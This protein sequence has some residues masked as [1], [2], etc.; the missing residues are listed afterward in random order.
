M[1]IQALAAYADT[2]LREQL[3]DPAFESKRVPLSLEISADGKFLGWIPHEETV[4]KGKKQF[5]QIPV[6]TVPK[7]PVN[8]NSGA[9]PLLA[10][11]D[12]KYVF[13]VGPWTKGGQESDHTEKH[14]KFVELIGDA[15]RSTEDEGLMACARFYD[16]PDQ[17]GAAR[18]AFDVKTTGGIVLSLHPDGPIVRRGKAQSFWREHYGKKFGTR[19]DA[20]GVGMCLVSGEIGAIAPTHDKIKG[21]ASI[22]G[23]ASGVALMSFDKDA[24]QS[25]GW[26]SC[27]NSPVSP[28]RAQAYVLAL[29]HLLAGRQ[30][31]RVD[32][33]GTAF[34]FWLRR[35]DIAFNPMTFLDEAKPD[36]ISRLLQ[37]KA[38]SWLGID[39]NDFYVLAVAGNGGRLVVRQWI[40]ESLTGV[41]SNVAA[42]FE[43]LEIIECFSGEMAA[44]PKTWEL[45]D[46]LARDEPPPGRAIEL[47]QRALLGRPLGLDLLSAILGRLRA[48]QGAARLK[49]TR[50]GLLRLAVNDEIVRNNKGEPM[51]NAELNPAESNPAYLCGRLLA[52][53]DTLQY[54]ASESKLNQTVA[55]RYYTLASTFPCLAFP[56]LEDLG[57]KHMRKLRG[58]KRSA[59]IATAIDRQMNEI[60]G[61]IGT[62]FPG[63]IN[64]V[65]Q[66]RF[67]LGFHHQR[68]EGFKRAEEAKLLKEGIQA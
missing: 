50:A 56:K 22:G 45:L 64:L 30:T 31:S 25:Y 11:D 36:D 6:Q 65:N 53:F 15:A 48:E 17:V 42:W 66:G 39:P 58:G 7:S 12:A 37:L 20:G 62:E 2:R 40:H 68:A 59:G 55:D 23:Q 41:L 13:G 26:E 52:L 3:D 44:A 29:N 43:G 16:R 24:F 18:E 34:L 28:N 27:A 51:M 5:K 49:A 57:L 67:A 1:L 35:P 33:N 38:N 54:Y 21:A 63:Q 14:A 60:R 9:H 4:T 19:N 61:Q 32:R 10:F 46:C 47:I 8:R